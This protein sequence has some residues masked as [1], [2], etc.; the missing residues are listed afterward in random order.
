MASRRTLLK[1]AAAAVAVGAVG[2][3]V[4]WRTLQRTQSDVI[5]GPW[6]ELDPTAHWLLPNLDHARLVVPDIPHALG[7][8]APGGYRRTRAFT[9]RSNAQRMRGPAV[10]DAPERW[11]ALGDSVTFGWGVAEDQAWPALLA[12]RLGVQVLNAGTPGLPA[13]LAEVWLREHAPRLA[14]A[15]VI[16]CLRPM[17]AGSETPIRS[18]AKHLRRPLHK[19]PDSTRAVLVLPPVSRFD[20]ERRDRWQGDADAL[21]EE[22]PGVQVV[23]TAAAFQDAQGTQGATLD[24]ADGQ[25]ILRNGGAELARAPETVGPNLPQP[26]LDAFDADRDVVE[27]LFFDQGHPDAAGHALL[28][29]LVG[30]QLRAG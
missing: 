29:Q 11:I 7:Q 5:T 16:L 4:L 20:T 25:W 13:R 28:A 2:G 21:R 14:P 6:P 18:L 26:I 3:G 9:V 15:G 12:A 24:R 22:L 27:P 10:Q 17:L 1:A 30:D 8:G 19:L 23:E